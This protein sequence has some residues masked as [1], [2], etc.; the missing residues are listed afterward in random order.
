MELTLRVVVTHPRAA[1]VRDGDLSETATE[2]ALSSR[3]PSVLLARDTVLVQQSTS[4][5]GVLCS[6]R[7]PAVV[8]KLVYCGGAGLFVALLENRTLAVYTEPASGGIGYLASRDIPG[9][10]RPVAF[11]KGS[12]KQPFFVFTKFDSPSVYCVYVDSRVGIVD[13]LKLRGD[14]QGNQE[15][16]GVLD[17][18]IAMFRGK[19]ATKAKDQLSSVVAI[20][21]HPNKYLAAAAYGNGIIRVWEVMRK[22]LR[23]QF[24]AQLLLRES[25]VDVALHPDYDVLI[26]CTDQGRV[27]VFAIRSVALNRAEEP[28]LAVSKIRDRSRRYRAVCCHAGK[29]AYVLLLTAGRRIVVKLLSQ[30]GHLVTSKRFP[31][32]SRPLAVTPDGPLPVAKTAAIDPKQPVSL[33]CEARCGLIA[34]SFDKTGNVYMYEPL[35]NGRERSRRVVV[36][37]PL[38]TGFSQTPGKAFKG[39]VEVYSEGIFAQNGCLYSYFIE[40]AELIQ[41]CRLPKS[42]QLRRLEVARDQHGS[43]LAVLAFLFLDEEVDMD[44][45]YEA[46]ESAS[47]Y[48]LVT[49]RGDGE[50]W[51][52]SEPLEGASGCFLNGSGRH[53]RILILSLDGKVASVRSFAG[54]QNHP[55]DQRAAA[56]PQGQARGVHRYK[57]SDTGAT[58]VFRTPFSSWCAVLYEDLHN[59]RLT[60]SRN[61][62]RSTAAFS[63]GVPAADDDTFAMDV[64]SSMEL[65]GDEFVLDARWQRLPSSSRGEQY[66]AAI[67]TQRRLYI[68]RD[69]FEPLA[70]FDFASID[71]I[72]PSLTSPTMCWLGPAVLIL[73]GQYLYAVTLDG[74]ADLI[75]GLSQAENSSALAAALPDRAIIVRPTGEDGVPAPMYS[76]PIGIMSILVR[77]MLSLPSA[78]NHDG[79][80]YIN[81]LKEILLSHDT[82]QGSEALIDVLIRNDLSPIAY[83]LASSESG[84]HNLPPLKRAAFLG[85]IG[86]LRGALR[87]A[88]AEYARLPSAESFH[89]GSELFRL[90]QRILNMAMIAGD[91]AVGKRC[92]EL[93][94]RRGTFSAFVDCEGGYAAL[95]ALTKYASES[96]YADMA[97]TMKSLVEKSA[98]S[99]IATDTTR[100]P[101][102]SQMRNARAGIA[103][104]DRT[105][106]ALGTED[107]CEMLVSVPFEQLPA[108]SSEKPKR[109]KLECIKAECFVN[110]LEMLPREKVT[111][112]RGD[113]GM[114]EEYLLQEPVMAAEL[115]AAF[116]GDSGQVPLT[117]TANQFVELPGPLPP[118]YV[119]EGMFGNPE[120]AND[121]QVHA[122][123]ATIQT[124][125]T[126]SSA[127]HAQF[128]QRTAEA[129][130]AQLGHEERENQ[131]F[132]D[133]QLDRTP[134]READACLQNAFRKIDERRHSSAFKE[135]RRGLDVLAESVHS[136]GLAAPQQVIELAHYHYALN[137]WKA[138]DSLSKTPAAHS[139]PGKIALAQ[140]TTVLSSL[141]LRPAHRMAALLV[142]VDAY[143]GLNNFGLAANA[144][145]TL[146][147][148]GV[149]PG[150]RADL[151][152]KY[153]QCMSCR[154]Q[155][156]TPFSSV[157]FC[158]YTL[159][160]ISQ[161]MPVV[162]C[163]FCPAFFSFVALREEGMPPDH[164]CL[165]CNIGQLRAL[166]AA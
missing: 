62:F 157:R 54:K 85:R 117:N 18:G 146:K 84:K 121:V 104:Y 65:I 38:D 87:V 25:I 74:D 162:K 107:I 52:V 89:N 118:G 106:I 27:M 56:A 78:R 136:G 71:N 92:S 139:L 77:G 15:K 95:S 144:M 5:L 105:A 160:L 122:T 58:Q 116:P 72:T 6:L 17:A 82:S 119:G 53:D 137:I 45:S 57:V 145:E 114:D 11:A 23:S 129:A 111:M 13:I 123:G 141:P 7:A 131:R 125:V 143:L 12:M 68:V 31:K 151:R 69:V 2:F 1:S 140:Y 26:A 166:H 99:C 9:D 124:H 33:K 66:L 32:L 127:E 22:E 24:D 59:H 81:K 156:L 102:A 164:S 159:R 133:E 21:A 47:Q 142:A 8:E 94:G 29:P 113:M 148:L 30:S 79:S 97:N 86:D 115:G 83:I 48:V 132:I 76:R 91:L 36:G 70:R 43:L 51:N 154:F 63:G 149:D 42:C 158:W 41:L 109:A 147:S 153:A 93:L 60:V 161:G 126:R 44:D 40:S 55:T 35:G 3:T 34:S 135:V 88:E 112:L 49:K 110:R 19:V 20:D 46:S 163:S 90:L 50:A 96:G 14:I 28:Q 4:T 108:G 120:R 128:V 80:H 134:E 152:A 165:C 37:S 75:A 98:K 101:S 130:E 10:D 155:N 103:A 73:F 64:E 61:S 100:M 67:M 150:V 39:P 16:V 138:M